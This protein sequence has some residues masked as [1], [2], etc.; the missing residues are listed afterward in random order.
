MTRDDKKQ[1]TKVYCMKCQQ[2]TN[3]A[4][5]A[6]HERTESNDDFQ[7]WLEWAIL[8]C[9]GCES[10][11]F[12]EKSTFS[13]DYD[14]Q[15]GALESLI[16][17]YPERDEHALPVE[18]FNNAPKKLRRIYREIIDAFNRDTHTLCAGGLRAIVAG[19]CKDQKVRCGPVRD[20]KTGRVVR[21]KNLEGKINGL[22]GRGLLTKKHATVLHKHRF[23]GN[24]ALHDLETP[25]RESLTAAIAIVE[26]TLENIYELRHTARRVRR[27]T[28]PQKR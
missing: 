18:P 12:M 24:E 13:D 5:V 19:I 26:H 21:R 23:L 1:T 11:T 10:V 20:K 2:T 15:T 4:I 25:T 17:Y 14:P 22:V 3:H 28:Q 7:L 16:R 27:R 9:A 8:Q 6:E